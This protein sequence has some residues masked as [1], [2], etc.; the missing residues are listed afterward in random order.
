MNPLLQ[1]KVQ[2]WAKLTN[3]KGNYDLL[4]KLSGRYTGTHGLPF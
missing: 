3:R 4:T 1:T 2:K